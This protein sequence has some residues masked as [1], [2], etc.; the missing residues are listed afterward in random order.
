MQLP[1]CLQLT[2]IGKSPPPQKKNQSLHRCIISWNF[3]WVAVVSPFALWWQEGAPSLRGE[4][5]RGQPG[6]LAC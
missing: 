1:P 2:F 3:L 5:P 4:E 6:S